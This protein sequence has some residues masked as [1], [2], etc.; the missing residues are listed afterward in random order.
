MK[1][2]VMHYSDALILRAA[3][4]FVDAATREGCFQY[5]YSTDEDKTPFNTSHAKKGYSL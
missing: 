1:V 5:S 3:S 4:F 2:S